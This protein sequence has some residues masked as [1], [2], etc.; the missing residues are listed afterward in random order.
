ML[1]KS[2]A[3]KKMHLK[4]MFMTM[5]EPAT[6]LHPSIF[7]AKMSIPHAPIASDIHSCENLTNLY[8]LIK[9]FDYIF[10]KR[11]E[12]YG[13]VIFGFFAIQLAYIAL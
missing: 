13:T 5:I 10:W 4:Q 6:I 1:V 12:I 11:G 8:Y 3:H 7:D 9:K 2:V